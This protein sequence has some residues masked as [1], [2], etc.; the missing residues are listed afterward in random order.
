MP[1]SS[2]TGCS[3]SFGLVPLHRPS[4]ASVAERPVTWNYTSLLDLV[5]AAVFAALI[6]LTLTRG[7]KDPICGMTVDRHAGGPTSEHEGRTVYFCS[8]SCK[9]TYDANLEAHS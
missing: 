8:D 1:R 6:C 7:A 5:G 9:H 2:S 4:V 3:R